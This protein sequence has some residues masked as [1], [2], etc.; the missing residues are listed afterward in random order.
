M[1][2]E[3]GF[4]VYQDITRPAPSIIEQYK[5][6]VVANVSDSLGS[7]FTMHH[8]VKPVYHG[9]R[10]L[11][12]PA[13]TV[14][15]RP[16]DNLLSLKAIEL[17]QPGDVI[18]IATDGDETRSVWGG[19]MSMMS[20]RKGLAGMVTDGIVRDVAQTRDENFAVFARGV[21]PVAPSKNSSGQINTT[22]SCAGVVVQPGDLVLGDEDGVVVV[23]KQEIE[24]VIAQ[25][26]ARIERESAW[27]KLVEGGELIPMDAIDAFLQEHAAELLGRKE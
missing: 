19:F 14:R 1:S 25:V 20:A 3:A 17:A 21:T 12:G 23:P 22:V 6:F 27:E 10:A 18:V 16:G 5:D 8:S 7:L 4:K 15:A 26:H 13:F 2:T 9:M 11:C 24:N